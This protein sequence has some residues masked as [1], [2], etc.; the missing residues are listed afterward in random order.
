MA[1]ARKKAY[2]LS[3]LPNHASGNFLMDY[4][5]MLL[6][7]MPGT[8]DRSKRSKEVASFIIKTYFRKLGSKSML[9]HILFYRVQM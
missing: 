2:L 5:D 9:S 4:L 7:N 8:T 1:K 6:K 3:T